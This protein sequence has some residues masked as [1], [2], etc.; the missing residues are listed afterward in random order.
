STNGLFRRDP[1]NEGHRSTSTNGVY[2]DNSN[3]GMFQANPTN[4]LFQAGPTNRV[5]L[6]HPTNGAFPSNSTNGMFRGDP[7]NEVHRVTSTD[8][9]FRDVPRNGMFHDN[10]TNGLFRGYHRNAVFHG[11]RTNGIFRGDPTTSMFRGNPRNNRNPSSNQRMHAYLSH[12]YS[13]SVYRNNQFQ[14]VYPR[15]I[16]PKQN[17]KGVKRGFSDNL[18][19]RKLVKFETGNKNAPKTIRCNQPA[20]QDLK[21][22]FEIK[23]TIASNRQR[24]F[25]NQMFQQTYS[26]SY[27]RIRRIRR[28]SP[29]VWCL[30]LGRGVLA[31]VPSSPSDCSLELRVPSQNRSRVA[32]KRD[33]N[34]TKLQTTT[35]IFKN[36][37]LRFGYIFQTSRSSRKLLLE[38]CLTVI[39]VPQIWY[40]L[41]KS[42]RI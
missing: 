26:F 14:N 12:R 28:K 33:V 35:I 5:F 18:F 42:T 29:L 19:P 10:P 27:S 41:D 24:S 1:R 3:N 4:G 8:R 21:K 37:T 40:E 30:S 34:I 39:M 11:N 23:S 2:R 22:I 25:I 16:N 6:S 31:Q 17:A 20:F 7:R 36:S 15:N 38:S 13:Q 9:V 32:S